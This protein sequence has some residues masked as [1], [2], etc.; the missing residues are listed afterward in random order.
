MKKSILTYSFLIVTLFIFSHCQTIGLSSPKNHIETIKY[1]TSFGHCVGINCNKVYTISKDE[2]VFSRKGNGS[3][4]SLVLRAP[5]ETEQWDNL[6]NSINDSGLKKLPETIGCPDCA[7]GGSEWV[8]ISENNKKTR[9]TFE[10]G[11][12]PEEIK[13]VIKSLKK[14]TEPFQKEN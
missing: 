3:T 11:K 7:D 9:V 13:S 10:Y 1:G 6:I 12:T 5:I 14:L 2:I 4:D 8:E